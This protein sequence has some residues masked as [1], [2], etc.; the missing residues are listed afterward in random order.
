[1]VAKAH[2]LIAAL[3]R[4]IDAVPSAVNFEVSDRP[5]LLVDPACR[6]ATQLTW[7]IP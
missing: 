3:W 7:S 6:N 2:L 5:P 4:M 1:M